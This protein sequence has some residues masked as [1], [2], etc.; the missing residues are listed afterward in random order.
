MGEDS[1]QHYVSGPSRLE[2]LAK[3]GGFSASSSL[4]NGPPGINALNVKTASN[5][6]GL[7]LLLILPL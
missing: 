2:P 1:I 5:N 7:S 6:R 3:A 4:P